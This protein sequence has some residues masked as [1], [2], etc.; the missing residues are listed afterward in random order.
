MTTRVEISTLQSVR[1]LLL[2]LE[3]DTEIILVEV[4]KPVAKLIPFEPAN[5]SHQE[6]IPDL[7]P[8]VWM[9]EDFDHFRPSDFWEDKY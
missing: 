6:R 5:L 2:L 8:G 4:N 3:A 1:D 9:R 7:H